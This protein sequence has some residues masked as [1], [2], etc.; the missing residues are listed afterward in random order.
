[1]APLGVSF[2]LQIEDQGSVEFAFSAI[3]NAF[4]FSGFMLCPRAISFFQKLCPA[5]FPPASCSFHEP[6]LGPQCCLYNILAG[7]P[8]N[9]WPLGGNY[10]IIS[11][12]SRYLGPH[13][14]CFLQHVCQQH[15]S[16]NPLGQVTG[17]PARSPSVG[18]SPSR[19]TGLPEMVFAT[20]LGS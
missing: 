10:C 13:L 3:L 4:N 9:S 19:A 7:Q 17:T 14:P 15:F 5:C 6:S 1:M 2:S 20:S 16:V 8:E 11:N 12:P 18:N